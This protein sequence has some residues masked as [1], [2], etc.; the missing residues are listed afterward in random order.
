MPRVR[1]NSLSP[2]KLCKTW[3]AGLYIRL[4]K[5]DGNNESYSVTNQRNRLTGY[6]TEQ[7]TDEITEVVDYYIDDG[8]SGTDSDRDDFQRLLEDLTSRKINCV[9]VKDLSRLSRND[10]ECGRYLQ[11]FF[12]S[13]DVRFI[14]LELPALDS[15][16]RPDEIYD[17]ATQFQSLMNDNHCRET[18]IKVRGTLNMK[19]E[20][21]LFIGAFA[22]YGYLKDPQ[23]KHRFIV[24][25]DTAPV[26]KDIFNWFVY[27]GM[28]KQAITKKLIS[29]G[30]LSP[31]AYK[32]QNGMN[33]H[34]PHVKDGKG[35]WSHRTVDQI[36]HNGTYLGHMIQ[37]KHKVKSYKVH[38]IVPI[39]EKDW[40]VTKNTHEPLVDQTTFDSAQNLMQRDTRTSPTQKAVYPFS[41]FLKC[42]DC[43][44]GMTRTA[45]KGYV[46]YA[47]KTYVHKSHD[48]CTRHSIGL[49]DIE[50]AVLES[51]NKQIDLIDGL[52][53]DIEEI[54]NAPV[55]H[56]VSLRLDH[57]LKQNIK[58]LEKTTAIKDDLYIDWKNGDITRD[59]YHRMK[60][61]FEATEQ[62]LQQNIE[63]LQAERA[64]MNNGMQSSNPYFDTFLKYRNVT[65][66]TRSL[67]VDLIKMI[68]VHEGKALT[69]DFNFADQHR[70]AV[71]FIENNHRTLTVV[72]TN[73]KAIS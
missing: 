7:M 47:C 26:V 8:Y 41:G 10:W 31:S 62:E 51:I 16:K 70:R 11:Q 18:S 14:S 35:L 6:V 22:P 33:Y 23:N 48:L 32:Q 54:N 34:N 17:I 53:K 27:D 38:T 57:A 13:L 20:Q 4:S 46:Y 39:D 69:I 15:Y 66:I 29:L 58:K 60:Q 56:T 28:S 63:N 55:V 52:S 71:E 50:K 30:I 45:G 1:K 68:Y 5:E 72:K 65:E 64:D 40:F 61:S 73:K 43:D 59:E 3:K 9:I 2:T 42:A 67:I 12:V 25:P 36:L 24:N 44:K 37:G 49:K 21:G 19:R